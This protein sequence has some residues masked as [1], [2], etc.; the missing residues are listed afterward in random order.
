MT[1]TELGPR[2][3]ED[4][5]IEYVIGREREQGRT[6]RDTRGTGVGDLLSGDRV[7]VV[8]ACGTSSRGHELWLEPSHYVAARGEPDG[9][10]LYLVENVAQGDPAH[11]RLI[12]LGED[13]LQELLERAREQRFWTVPVP[14][15]V[16]D[17]VARE[18]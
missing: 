3:I 16:Y 17:E 5:A 13:R 8:K 6:A 12:R 9:F 15:R 10:W 14:V 1:T 11:F 7:I 4:A 18:G 2:Q